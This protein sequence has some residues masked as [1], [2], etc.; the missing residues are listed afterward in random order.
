MLKHDF[1]LKFQNTKQLEF[2]NLDLTIINKQ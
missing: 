1:S 2:P